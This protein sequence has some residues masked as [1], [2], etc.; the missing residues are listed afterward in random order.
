MWIIAA[1]SLSKQFGTLNAQKEEEAALEEAKEAEA[2][3]AKSEAPAETAS[4][5]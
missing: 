3:A 4:T 2:M 1:K 5:T